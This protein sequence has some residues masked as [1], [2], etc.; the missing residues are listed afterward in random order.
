MVQAGNNSWLG[1][2]LD[3]KYNVYLS[4]HH[5]V[6][7]MV[8]LDTARILKKMNVLFIVHF[9]ILVSVIFEHSLYFEEN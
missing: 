1:S 3:V 9:H 5:Y 4:E 7:Y 2:S 6:A 8:N